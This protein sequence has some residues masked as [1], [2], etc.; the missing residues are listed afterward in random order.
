MSK[1]YFF[2]LLPV[3]TLLIP[4][5][6]FAANFSTGNTAWVALSTLL[7]FLMVPG[8]ACFYGGMVRSKDIAATLCQSV[9]T[10][11]VIGL[12]WMAIGYS[13]TFSG[14]SNFIGG[15]GH[16][17]LAGVGMSTGLGLSIPMLLFVMFQMGLAMLAP[18]LITGAF[19]ER[20][21][22]SSWLVVL[23][24]WSLLVYAPICHW[25]WTP[26]SLL[27]APGVIDFAGGYAVHMAAGFSALA[28]SIALG[29][30]SE[31]TSEQPLPYNTNLILLGTALL[32]F[33]WLGRNSGA[34]MAA[35]G[36]AMQVLANTFVA[37]VAAM[38]VWT[39]VDMKKDGQASVK[40][41]SIAVIAGLVAI[42]PA[43]GY[44]TLSTALITGV[45]A[46]LVCNVAGRVL[47]TRLKKAD[48]SLNVFSCH[49]VGAII[50]VLMTGL[51]ATKAINRGGANGLLNGSSDMFTAQLMG[52][53]AV[54]LYSMIATFIII[55]VVGKIRPLAK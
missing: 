1:K 55:K 31:A 13:L 28:A 36:L 33:G 45:L 7:V 27:S 16:A 46:G 40:G 14:G 34:A 18:L 15:F 51:L 23:V 41:S 6:A 11:G 38:L 24:L 25:I 47:K 20:V 29:K 37:S 10:A 19:A 22:F 52:I 26:R 50:G 39:L 44:V 21:R 35:N 8:F 48:D 5:Q 43:C 42:T 54:A 3:A 9:I 32:W 49:G 30:H 4:T 53:V 17:M 2:W 12:L